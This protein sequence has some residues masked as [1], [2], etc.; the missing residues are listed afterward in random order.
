MNEAA[1]LFA[2]SAG[3][4]ASINPCGFA[5]LP[6]FITFYLARDSNQ[7]P[8]EL[9]QRLLRAF[10]LGIWVTGGFLLV[11]VTVGIIFAVGGRALIE[12]TPLIGIIVGI[13]L[14]LAG[15]QSL[16]RDGLP[17]PIPIPEFS[18]KSKSPKAMFMYGIAYATVSLSCTL[19]IFLSVFAG[20][21][22]LDQWTS[23]VAL[24]FAYSFGMGTVITTLALATA[25]F[26]GAILQYLRRIIPH[27]KMISSVAL[28]ITGIYLVYY[29]VI[30]NP[31]L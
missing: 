12:I 3:I 10:L 29:Q 8:I 21:L 23:A 18:T 4:L 30:L 17:L 26:Q 24:F 20:S 7:E 16:L 27:V 25:L 6:T 14:I 13:I 1:L 31:F 5:M 11:F 9:H 22:V 19:P 2:F 15:L 28:I